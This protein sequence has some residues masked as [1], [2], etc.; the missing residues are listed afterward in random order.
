MRE[1]RKKKLSVQ[2]RVKRLT[3]RRLNFIKVVHFTQFQRAVPF[4]LKIASS[5][6]DHSMSY[7]SDLIF[8]TDG[9]IT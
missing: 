2:N 8:S 6:T 4:L 5:A 1:K 3:A 7:F 9:T